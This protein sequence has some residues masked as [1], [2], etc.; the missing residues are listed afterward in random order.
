MPL[1]FGVRIYVVKFWDFSLIKQF[2]IFLFTHVTKLKKYCE[3][4][5]TLIGTCNVK[6]IYNCIGWLTW[7]SRLLNVKSEHIA[8]CLFV[9]YTYMYVHIRMGVKY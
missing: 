1:F 5:F 2:E 4:K 9:A 7:L 3:K 6:I 8:W